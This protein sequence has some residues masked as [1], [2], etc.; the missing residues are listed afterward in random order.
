MIIIVSPF[1]CYWFSLMQSHGKELAFKIWL[2]ILEAAVFWPGLPGWGEI[3]KGHLRV[4]CFGKYEELWHT[5]TGW[6][7]S[8]KK[9]ISQVL[10]LFKRFFQ[11]SNLFDS[12]SRFLSPPPKKTGPYGWIFHTHP[13]SRV[14]T[15]P[16]GISCVALLEP[17]KQAGLVGHEGVR[18]ATEFRSR[19]GCRSLRHASTTELNITHTLRS[20]LKGWGGFSSGQK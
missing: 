14:M 3:A 7:T 15:N 19:D 20:Q 9:T 2:H 18:Q 16:G 8:S 5:F 6:R 1:T 12:G 17:W 4:M 13:W 11:G 10:L